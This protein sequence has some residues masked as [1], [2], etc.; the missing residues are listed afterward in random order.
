[1]HN[2]GIENFLPRNCADAPVETREGCSAW[3]LR[4]FPLT[5]RRPMGYRPHGQEIRNG[6]RHFNV[7]LNKF[8]YVLKV[9]AVADLFSPHRIGMPYFAPRGGLRKPRNGTSGRSNFNRRGSNGCGSVDARFNFWPTTSFQR[10][11]LCVQMSATRLIKNPE[12]ASDDGSVNRS[13]HRI[14]RLHRVAIVMSKR[15]PCF[16]RIAVVRRRSKLRTITQT[17][18]FATANVCPEMR[19]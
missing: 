16:F 5:R 19:V 10:W 15:P 12:N 1:M 18:H 6:A 4:N 2:N 13:S 17:S 9:W 14:H 7:L 11:F 8:M 3:S